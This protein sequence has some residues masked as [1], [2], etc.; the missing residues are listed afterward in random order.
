MAAKKNSSKAIRYNLATKKK[1]LAMVQKINGKN[2]RG[3]IAAVER[4]FGISRLTIYR[5][6]KSLGGVE[7][8]SRPATTKKVAKKATKKVAKKVT[9]KKAAK[10]K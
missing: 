3:G 10:K 9:K 6:I 8:K 1:A 7:V 4:E 2:S 5:W